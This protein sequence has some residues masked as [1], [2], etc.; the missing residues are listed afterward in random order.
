M[1][2]RLG[3]GWKQFGVTRLLKIPY[4]FIVLLSGGLV[5]S[6]GRH[7]RSQFT[8]RALLVA[9]TLI[10]IAVGLAV[11]SARGSWSTVEA[12]ALD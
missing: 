11:S 5:L 1:Q 4:W 2:T 12:K 8:V 6:W 3:F 10:A 7:R 9:A